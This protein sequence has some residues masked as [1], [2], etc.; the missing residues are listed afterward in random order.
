MLA[1]CHR[2]V[3]SSEMLKS[4]ATPARKSPSAPD[5]IAVPKDNKRTQVIAGFLR[6][7][8]AAEPGAERA[9]VEGAVID[10][11]PSHDATPAPEPAQPNAAA[12]E[13]ELKLLVDAERMAQFNAAP[14]IAA[15]AR[16]K[17]ARKHL[18]SVYY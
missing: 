10:Q 15:N 6:Q 7:R 12:R 11:T 3:M 14:V 17:G 5:G 9:I 8:D 18:K 1:L 13:I 2:T 16:N 4:D